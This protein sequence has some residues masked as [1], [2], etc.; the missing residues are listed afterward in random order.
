MA[1][2]PAS[3]V[4]L[5]VLKPSREVSMPEDECKK[6]EEKEGEVQFWG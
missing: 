3:R 4:L 6:E 2:H 1:R 5:D